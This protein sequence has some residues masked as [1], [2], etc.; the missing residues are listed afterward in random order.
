MK[1]LIISGIL[2]VL[3]DSL[4]LSSITGFFDKQ[5]MSVQKSPLQVDF[6]AAILC[7]LVL[8]IGLYYFIISK[9]K[10]VYEAFLLG[11][12]IYMVFELTNKG[13]LKNWKWNTVLLDGI[14]GGILFAT[15]TFITYKLYR[16]ID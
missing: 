13:I 16:L 2:L 5:V 11:F 3:I 1:D 9:K 6:L 10:P 15:T 12:V 7:Y 14:W 4:Y 8:I